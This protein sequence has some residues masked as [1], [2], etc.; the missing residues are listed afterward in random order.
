MNAQIAPA[1]TPAAHPP[2][3]L[4][5]VILDSSQFWPTFL[6]SQ[7]P[8]IPG[9]QHLDQ[10]SFFA[11]RRISTA[12]HE[13]CQQYPTMAAC[14]AFRQRSENYATEFFGRCGEVTC[15]DQRKSR[16]ICDAECLSESSVTFMDVPGVVPKMTRTVLDI[17]QEEN[18]VNVDGNASAG[19]FGSGA[20]V[21]CDAS[22][23]TEAPKP[24]YPPNFN[25][26]MRR[27]PNHAA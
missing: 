1:A 23:C 9:I 22:L 7:T 25:L 5:R 8:V 17:L 20:V 2:K 12:V 15:A 16:K 3:T 26:F 10:T 13:H 24:H 27:I 14:L 21:V 11:V 4:V 6:Q 18:N 19:S